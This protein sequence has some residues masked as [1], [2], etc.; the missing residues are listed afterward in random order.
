MYL[1]C[2]GKD[3]LNIRY[4]G[5]GGMDTSGLRVVDGSAMH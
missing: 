2:G 3:G 5:G 4:K 1:G